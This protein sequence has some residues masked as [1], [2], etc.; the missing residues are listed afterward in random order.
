MDEPQHISQALTRTLQPEPLSCSGRDKAILAKDAV[1]LAK[2][3]ELALLYWRPDFTP[4]QAKIV[5]AQY[6]DDLRDF[7][8]KDIDHAIKTYRRDPANKFF[9][10]PGA[11][12]GILATPPAWWA[13][14][15]NTWLAD[16]RAEAKRELDNKTRRLAGENNQPAALPEPTRLKPV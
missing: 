7:A 12:R 6:L 9:P 10:H 16:C 11:L 2:L 15:Q 3:N 5:Q 14:G 8:V 1:I 4:A 13:K